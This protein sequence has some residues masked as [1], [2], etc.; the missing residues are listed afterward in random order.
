MQNSNLSS[1][2]F[3]IIKEDWLS[4]IKA[5]EKDL[6]QMMI[7]YNND[8]RRIKDLARLISKLEEITTLSK[9]NIEEV[10]NY[11]E[12]FLYIDNS[13]ESSFDA[14]NYFKTQ[15][16]FDNVA[17]K[18][19]YERII[20]SSKIM[21][22]N[23]EYNGLSI[24]IRFDN[25]RIKKLNEL[26]QGNKVDYGLIKELLK[27]YRFDNNKKKNILLYTIVMLSIKQ[28]EINNSKENDENKKMARNNFY[29]DHF[30]ELVKK[31]QIIKENN[32][33]LLIGCFKIK[34]KM[35]KKEINM[36][37][38]F[39]S[40]PEE[41]GSYD[42]DDNAML[43]IYVLATFKIKKDIENYI[44]GIS[45]L[46]M[47]SS[48]LDDELVFFNEMIGEFENNVCRLKPLITS[49]E[50]IIDVADNNIYFA[51]DIFN[52][53]LIK[54]LLTDKNINNIR[55]LI[56]K[57]DVV[58]NS[59]IDGV[60]TNHMLGVSEEEKMLGKNISMLTTSKLRL[61]YITVNKNILILGGI[62]NNDKFDHLIK[63]IVNKNM[64]AIKNQ[65]SLIE[66][67]DINYI[68]LQNRIIDDILKEKSKI[69]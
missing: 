30:N 64:F 1:K 54:D 36:Y 39:S 38:S 66:K 55:A 34:E 12:L 21:M 68:E 41:A 26:L 13:L 45:D 32:K 57:V 67:E 60:K 65:I 19:I 15:G 14:L 27:K 6:Q 28:N 2:I 9:N 49:E 10:L 5:L 53:L 47:E 18:A 42:F 52:R 59:R 33:D 31:Y 63:V 48:D 35:N 61:A 50:E 4:F 56:Q 37:E 46:V 69:R 44:D 51:L 24:K 58:E 25:E 8:K 22:I 17:V 20:N 11:R 43:K 7:A 29:R 40:N 23:S 3:P 16:N 62:D